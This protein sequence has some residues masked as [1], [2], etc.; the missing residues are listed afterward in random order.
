MKTIVV[1]DDERIFY[2][3]IDG[4]DITYLKTCADAQRYLFERPHHG[5]I[6]ELFLDH[7]L[8]FGGTTRP[9]AHK[10]EELAFHGTPFDV[11]KIYIHTAN[12]TGADEIARALKGYDATVVHAEDYD[13]LPEGF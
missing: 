9:I 4:A 1:V 8:G 13:L 11:K 10:L 12:P 6:D 7:D 3:K 5:V 2:R